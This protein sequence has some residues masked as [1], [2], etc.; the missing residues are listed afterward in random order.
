[1]TIPAVGDKAPDFDLTLDSG[2]RFRLSKHKG[3]PVVL[4]FYSEDGTE[5]CTIQNQEFTAELPEFENLGVVVIGISPDTVEK[6]CKFRDKFALKVPLAADP[7][8]KAAN[9]Y[10]VWQQKK[11]Y[12]R[13]YMGIVRTSFLIDPKGK[14]AA[15]WPVRRIKGHAAV[16][17]DAVKS[18]YAPS[19]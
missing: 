1:M 13:E 17:L 4:Y 12:G 19:P 3:K 9:A 7:D 11:L 10:G 6:H 2:E 15:V 14:I 18:L 16:V 5:G 8:L